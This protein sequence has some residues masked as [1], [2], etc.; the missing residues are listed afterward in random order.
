MLRKLRLRQPSKPS[1]K[2][3]KLNGSKSGRT[4]RTVCAALALGVLGGLAVF[5]WH[6]YERSH[7]HTLARDISTTNVAA[8]I[9]GDSTATEPLLLH[10]HGMLYFG[11]FEGTPWAKSMDAQVASSEHASIVNGA[12]VFGSK[13]L[14]TTYAQGSYGSYASPAG[15]SSTIFKIPFGSNGANIG[16]HDDLYFRFMVKFEPGFQF[17]KSGKLPGLAGGTSNTAGN[18]PNGTDGW[19]GRLDWVGNGGL[20]SYLYVPGIKKYGLELTW[21]VAGK[22]TQLVQPGKWACLEMRYQMNTPGQPNG[23][24]QGWLNSKVALD[25]HNINFRSTSKLGIDNILFSTFF[26][27]ATADYASPQNQYADFDSFAVATQYIPCPG[28]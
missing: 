21:N 19:S 7:T 20:I 2:L 22:T 18:P 9:A 10:Q 4:R 15:T 6:Q 1:D 14:R 24:A 12:G 16:M 3:G 8:H 13:A 28:Q 23:I 26:G 25:N 11:G 17:G 27:G 5:G